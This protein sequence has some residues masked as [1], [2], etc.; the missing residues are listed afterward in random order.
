MSYNLITL[1]LLL[2][3]EIELIID[4]TKDCLGSLIFVVDSLLQVKKPGFWWKQRVLQGFR[5]QSTLFHLLR[6]SIK[7]SHGR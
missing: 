1:Y 5:G 4:A 7:L 6:G 3:N 2:K